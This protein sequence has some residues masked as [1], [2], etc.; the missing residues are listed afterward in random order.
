MAIAEDITG[1]TLDSFAAQIAGKKV[2]LLYPQTS[3]RKVFLSYCLKVAL[4]R[5]GGLVP[6]DQFQSKGAL[7]CPV[8]IVHAELVEDP[9]IKPFDSVE[10][11]Y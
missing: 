3:Y 1:R 9:A 5:P 2:A 7:N 6:S 4:R 8:A 11:D 10:G